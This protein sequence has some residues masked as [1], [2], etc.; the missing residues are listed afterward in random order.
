MLESEL[1]ELGLRPGQAELPARDQKLGL[2][3]A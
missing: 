3:Q 2:V 1:A